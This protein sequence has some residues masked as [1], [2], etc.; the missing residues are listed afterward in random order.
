MVKIKMFSAIAIDRLETEVNSWLATH[1]NY[2]IVN[3]Q[4]QTREYGY[5]NYS[6]CITYRD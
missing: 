1:L 3:V 5:H 4:Y 2:D 6:I